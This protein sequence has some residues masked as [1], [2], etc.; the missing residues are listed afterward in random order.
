VFERPTNPTGQLSPSAKTLV[1][2]PVTGL[3]FPWSLRRNNP[4]SFA[5]RIH[6]PCSSHRLL[7]RSRSHSERARKTHTNV[8][9][10]VRRIVPVAIR[11]TAVL[12]IVVER[13]APETT[14]RLDLSTADHG[15]DE[16]DQRSGI[17]GKLCD[18]F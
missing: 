2:T 3:G 9:V 18:Y 7:N 8:V 5:R 6:K 10:G 11:G 17:D 4:T 15:T 1:M 13:A 14:R 16:S 12:W